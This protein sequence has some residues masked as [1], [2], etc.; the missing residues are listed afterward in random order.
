MTLDVTEAELEESGIPT[1]LKGGEECVADLQC[2]DWYDPVKQTYIEGRCSGD[3]A[4]LFDLCHW[5]CFTPASHSQTVLNADMGRCFCR[6][7]SFV[8]KRKMP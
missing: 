5:K 2:S 8:S 4:G 6:I 1:N 3:D 7:Q